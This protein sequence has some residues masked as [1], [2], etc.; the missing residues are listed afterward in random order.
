MSESESLPE[1]IS[2]KERECPTG[3]LVVRGECIDFDECKKHNGFCDDKLHC[4]NSVGSYKCGCRDGYQTKTEVNWELLI[5][6]AYCVDTDECGN[7]GTCPRK[8]MCENTEG[9]YICQCHSGFGG[10][11]C[12]DINEC[13]K[14]STC[15]PNAA[16]LNTEGSFKCSCNFGYRGNG[17]T[18][19]VGE[20]EDRRC[21]PDQKCI[22]P[23]SD[24]CQCIEGLSYNTIS[25]LCEDVDECSLDHD[26]VSNSTCF[27]A[28][29]S[30]NCI[31]NQGFIGDGWSCKEGT[32]T[33]DMC[34]MNAECVMP[35]S[36]DC[37]CKDGYELW[38]SNETEIC[39]DTD[40]CSTQRGIC[41]EKAV[42][43]NYPG[44]YECSCQDGYFGDGQTCFPGSCTD[45]NCPSSNGKVCVSPRKPDC[46]CL[47]GFE[48]KNSS[49][50][51]DVD[52]CVKL[53]CHQNA[54]CS[55][56]PGSYSCLC[57]LGYV[58]NGTT[59]TAGTCTDDMC[60]VNQE[61]VKPSKLDCRCKDGYEGK[62]W[63]STCVDIDECLSDICHEKAWCINFPGGYECH[64][65]NG[66]VGD[67]ETCLPGSCSHINCPWT[68]HKACV[69]VTSNEC[70]CYG[71][72][73]M[74]K[75]SACVDIDECQ[76]GLCDQNAKCE[77]KP[78]KFS[79][80]CSSGFEG[81]GLSCSE[82]KTVLVLSLMLLDY[83]GEV[84][85]PLLVDGKGRSDSSFRLSL[86]FGVGVS[87]SCSVTYRNRFLVFGGRTNTG[88]AI[89][90]QISE[91]TKCRLKRIGTLPFNHI[92]GACSN[93]N[94]RFIYLCFSQ[95]HKRMCRSA[96]GPLEPFTG[97]V[98]SKY[99]HQRITTV[100]SPSKFFLIFI[101]LIILAELLA[102]G[103]K[104]PSHAKSEIYQFEVGCPRKI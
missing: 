59:C 83:E 93:I 27:N 49:V 104:N 52:E 103:N 37:R 69:S 74:N 85:L 32:C 34:P 28:K 67:G 51:I 26:C 75:W 17:I 94:D 102:V 46:K 8:S 4:I 66:Y 53:P 86:Y 73:E 45:S 56:K 33:D 23:T 95:G 70:K 55:N 29:G 20:C 87:S 96:E 39:V 54:K 15:D 16:C 90:T 82:L 101:L 18:C 62:L 72:F 57:R 9:S 21:P 35:T 40:E 6:E 81:D 25:E 89:E 7:S 99:D 92:G 44:R 43:T 5:N 76:R 50:C 68:D 19:K 38:T 30:Y 60:P 64:C 41:H 78:G 31:C 79:C 36:P 42:C 10:D 48:M 3:F 65:Q 2:L 63:E 100:A 88:H 13:N 98:P 91:V 80:T 71:G 12:E 47:E 11:L 84:K 58:G 97:I 22:S 1:K 14:T 24:E 61:C 77:N